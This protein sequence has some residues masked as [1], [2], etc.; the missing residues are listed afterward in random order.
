MKGFNMERRT[1]SE[2]FSSLNL[3]VMEM[4]RHTKQMM[5]ADSI[6]LV[7]IEFSNVA[8]HMIQAAVRLSEL[9][10]LK[11]QMLTGSDNKKVDLNSPI[12]EE[13]ENTPNG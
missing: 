11:Y 3:H 8:G 7:E 10:S 9:R 2:V 12:F 5:E 4:S 13:E 6:S 1:L